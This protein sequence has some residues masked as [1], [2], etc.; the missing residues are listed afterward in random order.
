MCNGSFLKILQNLYESPWM[1][2]Q[3]IGHYWMH[4]LLISSVPQSNEKRNVD[5]DPTVT[6]FMI[7]PCRLLQGR[8]IK[9]TLPV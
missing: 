3:Q 2:Q 8:M 4:V 9:A 1:W 7:S 6:E 5:E